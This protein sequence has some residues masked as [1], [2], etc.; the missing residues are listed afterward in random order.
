MVKATTTCRVGAGSLVRAWVEAEA[1][2]LEWA[3]QD[4][5]GCTH[6]PTPCSVVSLKPAVREH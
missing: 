4:L 6:P 1:P 3:C 2:G 5:P